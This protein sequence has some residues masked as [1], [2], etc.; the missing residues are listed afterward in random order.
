M[1]DTPRNYSI[2]NDLPASVT[3]STLRT[4]WLQYNIQA[5][6][7]ITTQLNRIDTQGDT[8]SLV[9]DAA[10]SAPE[11]TELDGNTTNPAG[12]LLAVAS[13]SIAPSESLSFSQPFTNSS[14]INVVHNL[15]TGSLIVDVLVG[16]I[17]RYDLVTE[18]NVSLTD[19]TNEFTVELSS[20]ETGTIEVSLPIEQ[21]VNLP[22][23]D[24]KTDLQVGPITKGVSLIQSM[25]AGTLKFSTLTA[26]LAAAS[27]G[28]VVMAAPDDYAESITVPADVT[29]RAFGSFFNTRISGSGATGTRV[30]LNNGSCIEGFEVTAPTDST[31][32]IDFTGTASAVIGECRIDSTGGTGVGVRMAG[33]GVLTIAGL[34]Y[35]GTGGTAAI[36]INSGTALLQLI[37]ARGSFTVPDFLQCNGGQTVASQLDISAANVTDLIELG[38]AELILRGCLFEQAT[39]AIHITSASADFQGDVIEFDNTLTTPILVDAAAAGAR[40]GLTSSVLAEPTL[41]IDPTAAAD[42]KL[43]LQFIDATLPE[44][45]SKIWGG[46]SVGHGESGKEASMGKGAPDVRGMVVITTDNTATSTTDGGNLTDVSSEAMSP[47]GSTFS[48]Q[49]TAA[50]HTILVGASLSDGSNPLKHFGLWTAQT[51]AAVE[52][53][54][55]SFA[56]ERWN[57]SSWEEFATMAVNPTQKYRYGNVL[58]IRSNINEMIRYGLTDATSWAQKSING[59]NL[60]WIRIR[61]VTALTTAPVFEQFK[62]AYNHV[63]FSESGSQT[64]HGLSRWRADVLGV[65]NVYGSTGG[66]AGVTATIGTGGNPTEWSHNFVNSHLLNPGDAIQTQL[67]IPPGTD[68]SQPFEVRVYAAVTSGSAGTDMVQTVSVKPQDIIGVM[69]ADPSGGTQPVTRTGGNTS[70]LTADPGLTSVLS[71]LNTDFLNKIAVLT[72]GPFDISDYYEGDM[73]FIRFELTDDGAA[74]ANIVVTA[75]EVSGIKWTTGEPLTAQN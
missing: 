15:G 8:L 2:A 7:V 65:G 59:D 67:V 16:G 40:V 12:G 66:V 26:A 46:L 35:T 43:L 57:G 28:D 45:T 9:F 52:A 64:S 14:S 56:F 18:I 61:I 20:A 31:Y 44:P 60:F 34:T 27:A 72:F 17:S 21:K 49:G 58:F 42:P 11:I 71:N 13:N 4:A 3:Q 68:T 47:S 50:N 36:V 48:F 10:L 37:R 51:T 55:K 73:L 74:N 1:P 24:E 41:N 23:P 32:G 38:A 54:A 75:M 25:G 62:L 69:V 6:S 70:T 53:T 5:N 63:N 39:N 29:L 33:S 30:T 19:P 22:N